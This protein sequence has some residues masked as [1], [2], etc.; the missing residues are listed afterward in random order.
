MQE[1]VVA[2][3]LTDDKVAAGVVGPILVHMVNLS[4][5]RNGPT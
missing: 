5:E 2:D 4:P 3:R 1:L